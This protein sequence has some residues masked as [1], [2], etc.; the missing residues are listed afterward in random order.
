MESIEVT[1]DPGRSRF[2]IRVDGRLAGF[3]EYVVHGAVADFTHTEIDEQ[4]EGRGLA[5]R[6]I[7]A[8]LDESRADGRQVMPYCPFVKSYI[9][10]HAEYA[11]LVPAEA[12]ARFGL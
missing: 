2:E 1:D 8:A 6:L 4:F 10:K 7:A 5:G 3:A 9:G 11:D 12:R